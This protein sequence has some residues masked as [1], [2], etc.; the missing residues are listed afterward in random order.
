[1]TPRLATPRGDGGRGGT[2][3]RVHVTAIGWLAHTAL[4][5]SR[6]VARVVA[7]L[8]ESLYLDAAGDL[9]WLGGPGAAL[10]PRA[11]I[12]PL[13]VPKATT[14]AQVGFEI[15]GARVWRPESTSPGVAAATPG[16]LARAV[17]DRVVTSD[18]PSGFGLLL[19]GRRPA[20][21]LDGAADRARDLASA[22]AAGDA[23]SA[24]HAAAALIG[25]GPGL[26]PAGDDY[27]GGALFARAVLVTAGAI[28][29]DAAAWRQATG[30]LLALAT[31]RTHPISAVL[32]SDLA[33]GH[34]H[35]P[36]HEVA[37][38]LASGETA[39]AVE[40]ARRLTR[41]GHSSGWDVL[42]G[43]LGALGA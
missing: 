24:E 17:A 33:A 29:A 43:F 37:A 15:E 41:I 28:D 7:P 26:T 5:R 14:L 9:I 16:A 42:A 11:V 12:G 10:H 31:A 38:A 23:A 40:A 34:G 21:P 18:V 8:S 2:D 35:A 39:Q 4:T 3:L 30:R 6:G 27:V 25:L 36:L 1:V 20:F 19:A 32:L 22:C 13:R